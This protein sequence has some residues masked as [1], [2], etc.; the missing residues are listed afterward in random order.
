VRRSGE[1]TLHVPSQLY[2][3]MTLSMG[4]QGGLDVGVLHAAVQ[5]KDFFKISK[6]EKQVHI[7]QTAASAMH[8]CTCRTSCAAAVPVSLCSMIVCADAVWTAGIRFRAE[9]NGGAVEVILRPNLFKP[10][11]AHALT[12]R[13]G[14]NCSCMREKL[15]NEKRKNVNQQNEDHCM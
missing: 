4:R 5:Y 15:Q 6:G 3:Y 11:F 7:C 14:A 12:H 1:A 8:V 10:L 9:V 13:C 2:R